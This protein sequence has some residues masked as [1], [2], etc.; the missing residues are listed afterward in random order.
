MD[1]D[2]K[3]K[4]INNIKTILNYSCY[5]IPLCIILEGLVIALSV[6]DCC[7]FFKILCWVRDHSGLGCLYGLNL[8][9]LGFQFNKAQF[10][11]RVFL[12]ARRISPAKDKWIQEGV[13]E[14]NSCCKVITNSYCQCV[15]RKFLHENHRMKW[16]IKDHEQTININ[17]SNSR[18]STFEHVYRVAL[19]DTLLLLANLALMFTDDLKYLQ[20]AQGCNKKCQK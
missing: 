19:T 13:K 18:F 7:H 1:S 12:T 20:G 6:S 16:K 8:G 14:N 4:T 3:Q 5:K 17:Y 9:R 10:C 15:S 2:A 11:L